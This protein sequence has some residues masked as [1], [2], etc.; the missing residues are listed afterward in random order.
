MDVSS[1]IL[2]RMT[3]QLFDGCHGCR[4]GEASFRTRV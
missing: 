2:T 3:V 1:R 4:E